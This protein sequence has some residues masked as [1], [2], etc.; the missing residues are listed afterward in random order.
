MLMSVTLVVGSIPSS[1]ISAMAAS[2]ITNTATPIKHLVVLF[3]GRYIL[4]FLSTTTRMINKQ[5]TV[6]ILLIAV[7]AVATIGIGTTDHAFAQRF[8]G[9]GQNDNSQGNN[10]NQWSA[11][12]CGFG[13]CENLQ[14]NQN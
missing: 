10:N 14:G 8:G 11:G 12:R 7:A 2:A 13:G 1:S 9:P 3:Q 6:A 4:L 5:R